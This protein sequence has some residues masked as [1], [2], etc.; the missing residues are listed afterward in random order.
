M[1]KIIRTRP[2]IVEFCGQCVYAYSEPYGFLKRKRR[3]MCTAY[4]SLL[5]NFREVEENGIPEWC[6]LEDAE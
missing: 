3:L 2:V 1:A 6:Q 4:T 5:G